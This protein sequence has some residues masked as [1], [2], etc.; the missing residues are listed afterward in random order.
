MFSIASKATVDGSKRMGRKIKDIVTSSD[1]FVTLFYMWAVCLYV[2]GKSKELFQV[3]RDEFG[4]NIDGQVLDST[5]LGII[6]KNAS[7]TPAFFYT[8]NGLACLIAY[9]A[10]LN[11][12]SIVHVQK[13][14]FEDVQR[15]FNTGTCKR[16]FVK[17]AYQNILNQ[18]SSVSI[19]LRATILN[20]VQKYI[21]EYIDF[22]PYDVKYDV[23]QVIKDLEL[24]QSS[25]YTL[26]KYNPTI[27]SL[28]NMLEQRITND[29]YYLSRRLL[30]AVLQFPGELAN[31]NAPE[32]LKTLLAIT[33]F[34]DCLSTLMENLITDST[35]ASRFLNTQLE[36]VKKETT[37]PSDMITCRMDIKTLQNLVEKLEAL[38]G[39]YES[40]AT[41][42]K[43]ES[44]PKPDKKTKQT[45][46]VKATR[47][48]LL[49]PK[50]YSNTIDNR[51]IIDLFNKLFETSKARIVSNKFVPPAKFLIDPQLELPCCEIS[52]D[53]GKFTT[54]QVHFLELL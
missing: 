52:F 2:H 28:F 24:F 9:V 41:V 53:N 27:S 45:Q 44:E 18:I 10:E 19:P 8:M 37:C 34:D 5:Y 36:C 42:V 33:G 46:K 3:M 25:I 32:F 1:D 26:V 35:E 30:C 29:N 12:N 6:E 54:K 4:H 21:L 47:S 14:L 43:D 31:E 13:E 16:T 7:I 11:T 39:G 50:T 38:T 23:N 40:N 22:Q 20:V 17:N 49:N 15:L 51:R 48:V